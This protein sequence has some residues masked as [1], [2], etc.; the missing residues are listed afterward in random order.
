MTEEKKEEAAKPEAKPEEKKEEPAA[1]ADAPAETPS[2][3]PADVD[4]GKTFAV[5]SYVLNF[6]SLPFFIVP[7]IMR[8]ND[9]SLYHAKQCLMLWL[10]GIV[11]SVVSVPLSFVCVGFITAAVGAVLLLVLNILGL[12]NAAKG[13]AKPLPIIGKWGEDW[14]KG[15]TKA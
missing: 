5:L 11:I 13:E 14:F 7:L 15:I 4:D 9:F 1:A 12:V 10:A 8:N 2:A 3:A 6:V